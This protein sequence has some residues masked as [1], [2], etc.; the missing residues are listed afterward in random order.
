MR[1]QGAIDPPCP[2]HPAERI[3]RE[4]QK[5]KFAP[6]CLPGTW[7]G[8]RGFQNPNTSKRLIFFFPFIF[9]SVCLKKIFKLNESFHML[10]LFFFKKLS[11]N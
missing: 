3:V 1:I 6:Q 5:E 10:H 2:A 4:K 8:C 11:N 7:P 9:F